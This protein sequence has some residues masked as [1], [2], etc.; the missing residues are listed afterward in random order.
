M[1]YFSGT[2]EDAELPWEESN[3]EVQV[4]ESPT[5]A[6][7]TDYK[8]LNISTKSPNVH[9]SE[10]ENER[11]IKVQMPENIRELTLSTV[12][13]EN[14]FKRQDVAFLDSK[15]NKETDMV[16]LNG[17]PEKSDIQTIRCEHKETD[18]K[19]IQNYVA[20]S[21]HEGNTH[22]DSHSP[23]GTK[24]N[25]TVDSTISNQKP[26]FGEEREIKGG[27][28]SSLD[29][30]A[31]LTNETKSLAINVTNTDTKTNFVQ[32][33][34]GGEENDRDNIVCLVHLDKINSQGDDPNS[35]VL[36]TAHGIIDLAIH[37]N[38]ADTR[39]DPVPHA[40]DNVNNGVESRKGSFGD[41]KKYSVVSETGHKDADITAISNS[42]G[43]NTLDIFGVQS[44]ERET[45]NQ[46]E[47]S[48]SL[49]K[50]SVNSIDNIQEEGVKCIEET[51]VKHF[52][53]AE[54]QISNY[55][56]ATDRYADDFEETQAT[57]I[58][59]IQ[60]Q[61]PVF[62]NENFSPDFKQS[63]TDDNL[64]AKP[65]ADVKQLLIEEISNADILDRHKTRS[66]QITEQTHPS[67]NDNNDLDQSTRADDIEDNATKA[68]FLTRQNGSPNELSKFRDRYFSSGQAHLTV[69]K[70]D[71]DAISNPYFT[72]S[73][74]TLDEK[75]KN[76]DNVEP[77][78]E[79]IEI[80][81]RFVNNI[82]QNGANTSSDDSS[83]ETDVFME[84][85]NK[86]TTRIIEMIR[87]INAPAQKFQMTK[88]RP[89]T[90]KTP[91][92]KRL[93]KQ[94]N[95]NIIAN[96]ASLVDSTSTEKQ[97]E[98]S[99][100]NR[101]YLDCENSKMKIGD[102]DYLTSS[103][104]NK[105][106]KEEASSYAKFD[107][108]PHIQEI[109]EYNKV[110][111][112]SEVNSAQELDEFRST[113]LPD[114][115]PHS[116]VQRSDNSETQT[117]LSTTVVDDHNKETGFINVN[118]T[119]EQNKQSTSDND[120]KAIVASAKLVYGQK[121]T[122]SS[123][124]LPPLTREATI[125]SD[126]NSQMNKPD[127]NESFS[128]CRTTRVSDDSSHVLICSNCLHQNSN[129]GSAGFCRE[130]QQYLCGNCISLHK[131]SRQTRRHEIM[132]AYCVNE[133]QAKKY[134][135]AT[136]YCVDC[137]HFLCMKCVI[138]HT[139]YRANRFHRIIQSSF[140]SKPNKKRSRNPREEIHPS[141]PD[142]NKN[143]AVERSEPDETKSKTKEKILEDLDSNN[144]YR[145]P[146]IHV[147]ESLYPGPDKKLGVSYADKPK[148]P[149]ASVPKL[150]YLV[151]PKSLQE[152][153]F[154]TP[155]VFNQKSAFPTHPKTA[156]DP[157]KVKI[158][159]LQARYAP[160][161]ISKRTHRKKEEGVFTAKREKVYDAVSL[162]DIQSKPVLVPTKKEQ[163]QVSRQ[164]GLRKARFLK[165]YCV[166]VPFP[167]G[168]RQADI[169][170]MTCLPNG[171]VLIADKQNNNVKL[172]T[173]HFKFKAMV[174]FNNR[175][176]DICSSN[177]CPV[178]LY[179]ATQKHV[180][181][182]TTRRKGLEVQ[183]KIKVDIKRIEGLT[184]WKYGLAVIYK[185]TNL[186]WE[187][188]LMDYRGN[189]KSKLEI[190]NPFTQEIDSTPFC[191]VTTI[192]GGKRI[193]LSDTKNACMICTD[194]TS[195]CVVYETTLPDESPPSY[196]TS[197]DQHNVYVSC[198]DKIQQLSKEGNNL[199][200]VLTKP[201][202]V[203]SFGCIVFDQTHNLLYVQT[204]RDSV[205]VYQMP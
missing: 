194:V 55:S 41:D 17:M 1:I 188:R 72:G 101:D 87:E 63:I 119:M 25:I 111:R 125:E 15:I 177:L 48:I 169:L 105:Y 33:L 50:D 180:V 204:A 80:G 171:Q 192:K 168:E 10:I 134:V 23:P 178:D 197:D 135:K 83:K 109:S 42:L 118:K 159:T 43:D 123:S 99:V 64:F 117:Q 88:E 186:T 106:A 140:L 85:D 56:N 5:T 7:T 27:A 198:I 79:N 103:M 131:T 31:H 154:Q 26:V 190:V 102:I 107:S 153:A 94:I 74:P 95:R 54:S 24:D 175:L 149:K 143:K 67:K 9:L 76:K 57:E 45:Q 146:N 191:Y 187:V 202:H 49:V 162:P 89:L 205:S 82:K 116:I 156:F 137:Q 98:V 75:E 141:F 52:Y 19:S 133:L 114:S 69:R 179:V 122:P 132:I 96:G 22:S 12:Q 38:T 53:R 128:T 84:T 51:N 93:T 46:P 28:D 120:L 3:S 97:N 37:E 35:S 65:S 78:Y 173:K 142:I 4:I 147:S 201:D 71:V 115:Q 129:I 59:I 136:G 158:R 61:L 20:S 127:T 151:Q 32:E 164:S 166:S 11:G 112:L 77:N 155:Y 40:G 130:C 91:S 66:P 108:F 145:L 150:P 104:M 18:R 165:E 92:E 14:R 124:L 181:E 182:I 121:T 161:E 6:F 29:P 172:Y 16:V 100:D 163:N 195:R 174:Q 196:V 30:R 44:H 203:K 176:S 167:S 8:D 81:N 199:G 157:K 113:K 152:R 200:A 73:L 70:R 21:E 193:I 58:E 139:G 90:P 170:A 183:K 148:W 110:N 138:Q 184:C 47:N 60:K 36:T 39:Q 160:G 68:I 185:K 34:N 13:E 126:P 189:S 62:Q 86:S 2:A 144:R